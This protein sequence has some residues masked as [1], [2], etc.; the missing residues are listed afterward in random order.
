MGYLKQLL[1]QISFRNFFY[2]IGLALSMIV[3]LKYITFWRVPEFIFNLGKYVAFLSLGVHLVITLPKYRKYTASALLVL[4]LFIMIGVNIDRFFMLFVTVSLVLGAKG[5]SFR[6]IV[7]WYFVIGLFFCLITIIGSQ[8]GVIDNKTIY[9]NSFSSRLSFTSFGKRM[10]FGYVWPTDFASHCFFIILAYWYI[11]RALINNV[12]KLAI[13]LLSFI[14]LYFTD[15]KLGCGCMVLLVITTIFYKRT[16]NHRKIYSLLIFSIPILAVVAILSTIMFD[17]QHFIW[18][19][20]DTVILAGRLYL[21]ND[22]LNYYRVT[23]WGQE[24]K[25][26]GA[27]TEKKYYNF[28]DSSYIQSLVIFGIAYTLVILFAYM[29]I[30]YKAY[31]RNDFVLMLA[32]LLTGISGVIAQHFLQI[33]MNPFLIALTAKHVTKDHA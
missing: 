3:L 9:I 33:F 15:A 20:I 21:G 17:N 1:P 29:M 8:L 26:Y 12:E 11:R 7:K 18:V 28:I 23:F 31:K 25:M 6:N 32:I 14:I 16:S 4:L 10:S 2:V 24:I 13:L 22:A 30:C 27:D 19:F 5:L